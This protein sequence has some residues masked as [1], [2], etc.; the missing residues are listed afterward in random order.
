MTG[1]TLRTFLRRVEEISISRTEAHWALLPPELGRKLRPR[2]ARLADSY[3]TLLETSDSLRMNRVIGLGHRG[4][5]TERTIDEI[6]AFYRAARLRRFSILL[7]PGPQLEA[8]TRWLEA[9]GFQP[10]AGHALLARDGA[11]PVPRVPSS[12]RIARARREDAPAMVNILQ[13]C[14]GVPES[15]EAWSLAAA[16]SPR[17]EHFLAFHGIKPVAVGSL[18]VDD[19]LGWLGGAATLT[20][21]R[22]RG[23]QRA[24]IAARLRSAARQECRW[25]WVETAAEEPGRPNGSRRNML[26]MGFEQV[27]VKPSWTWTLR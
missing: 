17:Y 2:V 22:G 18:G 14:F 13:R 25:A 15:R 20:P 9:R 11:R 1:A 10:G 6:I 16:H 8:I 5:A 12:L 23:A 26:A 27:C 3:L 21:W 7:C 19:D 4:E 24:L